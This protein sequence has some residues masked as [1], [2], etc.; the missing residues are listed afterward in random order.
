MIKEDLETNLTATFVFFA[1]PD[2]RVPARMAPMTTRRA[3]GKT[4]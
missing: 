4:T 2:V 1:D 3:E